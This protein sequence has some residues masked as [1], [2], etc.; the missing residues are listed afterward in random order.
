MR[1]GAAKIYCKEVRNN[2]ETYYGHW[3]PT[4][5]VRL[6]DY[7]FLDGNI[8]VYRG[9]IENAELF[10]QFDKSQ[11]DDVVTETGV[12]P[13]KLSTD[14][15]VEVNVI[16]KGAI[17]ELPMSAGV[18]I[19][20]KKGKS[21]FINALDCT[22]EKY[23]NINALWKIILA[24]I[25]PKERK[26]KW[27]IVS[28]VVK[29][30]NATIVVSV[31]ANSSILL[32]AN[33][34]VD[35]I[36]LEDTNLSL[37]LVKENVGGYH[38]ETTDKAKPFIG[39]T[40]ISTNSAK[41]S[42]MKEAIAPVIDGKYQY[43]IVPQVLETF[44]ADDTKPTTFTAKRIA[45]KGPRGKNLLRT[46]NN[47]SAKLNMAQLAAAKTFEAYGNGQMAGN[48]PMSLTIKNKNEIV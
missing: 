28:E 45:A 18:E 43:K 16:A 21:V 23:K 37:K 41:G 22:I 35:T 32:G 29:S 39:L 9:H 11:L 33:S 40:R 4:S 36:D 7:G 3:E 8:F 26:K 17:E 44:V 19:K 38:I 6:G 15:S 24:D 13:K 10:S 48:N 12:G 20:F 47:P 30:N 14:K 31:N 25:N 5:P 34:G 2:M 27:C 1:K 46:I 42:K